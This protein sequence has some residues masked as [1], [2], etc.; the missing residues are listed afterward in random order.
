M[1]PDP[2]LRTSDAEREETVTRLRE[3]AA[4]GR[5]DVEELDQRIG[6]AYAAR[7][8]G[9]LARL[10]A[11]LPRIDA[12]RPRRERDGHAPEWIVYAQ[13]N[14]LLIAIWAVSGAGYFWPAWVMAWWGLAI[15]LKSAPRMLR[16]R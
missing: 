2:S 11:D 10:Q 7:T 15:V 3:H 8:H 13:V 1:Q 14:A 12:A 4:A 6:A 5:L 16:L 9:E